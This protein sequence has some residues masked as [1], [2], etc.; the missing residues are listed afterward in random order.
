MRIYQWSLLPVLVSHCP[1]HVRRMTSVS[2]TFSNP[3]SALDRC[4]DGLSIY[5]GQCPMEAPALPETFHT[6][7]SSQLPAPAAHMP[8]RV[9][10]HASSTLSGHPVGC[11][12]GTLRPCCCLSRLP[13]FQRL[14]WSPRQLTFLRPS[15][16]IQSLRLR[17]EALA[18]LQWS[19]PGCPAAQ[20]CCLSHLQKAQQQCC[21][22]RQSPDH[23]QEPQ[24]AL[25]LVLSHL[26]L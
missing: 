20:T 9:R 4:L 6:K 7:R 22:R 12:R 15:Q 17:P 5:I 16:V 14:C 11:R 21:S 25:H 13:R 26:A 24:Q 8:S 1:L 2:G 23:P 19:R 10:R 3:A 18:P